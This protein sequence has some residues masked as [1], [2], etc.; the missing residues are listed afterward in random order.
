MI[1]RLLVAA[2]ISTASITSHAAE[3]SNYRTIM[4]YGCHRMD[5]IC[6]VNLDGPPMTG[7]PGCISNNIR[8]DTKNDVNG[9]NWLAII[10]SAKATGKRVAFQIDG[11]QPQFPAYPTFLYGHVEP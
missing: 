2:F 1:F 7:G 5:G 10:I 6:Y 4:E 8:W 9:K 11:C 3:W